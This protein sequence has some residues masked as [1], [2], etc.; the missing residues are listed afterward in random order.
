[1]TRPN[2]F[3]VHVGMWIMDMVDMISPGNPICDEPVQCPAKTGAETF[4]Y[5]EWR[6]EIE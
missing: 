4:E 2:T 1:M 6:G 3:R 5:G